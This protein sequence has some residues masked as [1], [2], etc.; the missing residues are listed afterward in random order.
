MVAGLSKRPPV[1]RT[2]LG[3]GMQFVFLQM[4]LV[5]VDFRKAFFFTSYWQILPFST[6][7][8]LGREFETLG[9][10]FMVL[11]YAYLC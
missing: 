8:P 1:V 7:F 6:S 11:L 5:A 3:N 10:I 2:A 4:G 9:S